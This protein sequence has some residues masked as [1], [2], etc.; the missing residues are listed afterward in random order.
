MTS[1]LCWVRNRAVFT[2]LLFVLGYSANTTTWIKHCWWVKWRSQGLWWD[3]SHRQA[4]WWNRERMC[5]YCCQFGEAA[6]VCAGLRLISPDWRIMIITGCHWLVAGSHHSWIGGRVVDAYHCVAVG[7]SSHSHM[8]G[9]TLIPTAA[10]QRTAQWFYYQTR[11]K[12]TGRWCMLIVFK[13]QMFLTVVRNE[14]VSKAKDSV[15]QILS[16]IISNELYL[17][18]QYLF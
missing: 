5:I 9:D 16:V 6:H 3:F 7:N 12:M 2:V 13:E 11:T 8:T 4:V 14:T 17:H 15:Q 1:S 10:G 18:A